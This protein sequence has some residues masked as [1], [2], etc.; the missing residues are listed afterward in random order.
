[1][2]H[3]PVRTDISSENNVRVSIQ[4]TAS[5]ILID[6]TNLRQKERKGVSKMAGESE[7][8]RNGWREK[9]KLVIMQNKGC[10]VNER[11]ARVIERTDIISKMCDIPL[12]HVYEYV[13]DIS[14]TGYAN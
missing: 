11:E 13:Q 4:W 5:K 10:R 12:C 1:V 14:Y 7:R 6:Y 2:L 8:G 9:E 3:S